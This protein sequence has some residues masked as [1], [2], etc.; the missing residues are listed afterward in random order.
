VSSPAF[1]NAILEQFQ[2]TL[3]AAFNATSGT[4]G[5]WFRAVRKGAVLPLA[6]MRPSLTIS[7]AGQRRAEDQLDDQELGIERVMTVLCTIQVGENWDRETPAETWSDRVEA[8]IAAGHNLNPNRG[9]L[10]VR[11][12][13][14]EPGQVYWSSGESAAVWEVEF[15]VHYFVDSLALDPAL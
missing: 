10:T 6:D 5:K 14:D 4:T 11:Y 13:R 2:S 9:A 15:E 8:V 12:V 7:D 3:N 1:R